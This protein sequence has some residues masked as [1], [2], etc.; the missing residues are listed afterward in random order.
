M[1][2]SGKYKDM[3]FSMNKVRFALLDK[4]GHQI[5]RR[6]KAELQRNLPT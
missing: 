2:P 4:P 3:Y 1:K 6:G 5:P